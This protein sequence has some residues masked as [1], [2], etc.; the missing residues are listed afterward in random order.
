MGIYPKGLALR[1]V[2]FAPLVYFR[3]ATIAQASNQIVIRFDSPP[4]A[5]LPI[6]MRRHYCS[7]L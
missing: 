4:F 2:H 1:F 5:A 3:M 7:I 6:G